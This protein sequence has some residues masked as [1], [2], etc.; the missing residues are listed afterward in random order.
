[1]ILSTDCF[2]IMHNALYKV[3]FNALYTIYNLFNVVRNDKDKL[4]DTLIKTPIHQTIFKEWYKKE[5][6]DPVWKAVRF[7]VLS[8]FSLLGKSDTLGFSQSHTKKVLLSKIDE[9]FI[10]VQNV[11]FMNVDFRKVIPQLAF[12]NNRPNQRLFTFIYAGPTIFRNYI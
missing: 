4:V 10:E 7:L 2:S 3:R 6:H 11:R 8:N 5:E 12:R 1:M 9:T